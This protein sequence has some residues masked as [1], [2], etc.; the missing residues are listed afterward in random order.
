MWRWPSGDW[1]WSAEERAEVKKV[2]K[3]LLERLKDLL[4]LDWRKR[5][6]ARARIDQGTRLQRPRRFSIRAS[7]LGTDV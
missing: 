7:R 3:R 5:Q 6:A 4:V 2:A 1:R